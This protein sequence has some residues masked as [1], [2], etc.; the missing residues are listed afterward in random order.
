MGRIADKPPNVLTHLAK[1]IVKSLPL[2]DRQPWSAKFSETSCGVDETVALPRI[3][4]R[5][6]SRLADEATCRIL[7]GVAS[8]VSRLWKETAAGDTPAA[9][10]W[11]T[12]VKIARA[13]VAVGDLVWKLNETEESHIK[14]Q[15]ATAVFSIAV[16]GSV[17]ADSTAVNAGDWATA[18]TYQAA[19]LEGQQ[20]R[21]W[22]QWFAEVV[23]V[24]IQRPVPTALS[25]GDRCRRKRGAAYRCKE[26]PSS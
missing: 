13:S 26:K 19:S 21:L 3:A 25:R 8:R 10:E 22:W 12:V 1:L 11:A 2:P 9:S 24:E 17:W 7:R 23:C 6:V 15:E 4:V 20:L 16:I 18:I 5:A 14:Y